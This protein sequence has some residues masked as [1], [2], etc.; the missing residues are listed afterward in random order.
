MGIFNKRPQD[1][2]KEDIFNL[3]GEVEGKQLDVKRH[4]F[5]VPLSAKD[6]ES[7]NPQS[8]DIERTKVELCT[9]VCAMANAHGGCIVLGAKDDKN[10]VTEIT[11]LSLNI[12]VEHAV[13][14]LQD[15]ALSGIEPALH[16]LHV[17][18]VVISEESRLFVI[19]ICVPRSLNA[20][21]WVKNGRR[22]VIRRSVN[23]ADMDI[24]EIRNAFVAGAT[25]VER[26][27]K[28]R[29]LR[30]ETINR[31]E[32]H[33]TSDLLAKDPKLVVHAIPLSFSDETNYDIGQLFAKRPANAALANRFLDILIRNGKFNIQG[34]TA[35]FRHETPNGE[36]AEYVHCWRNGAIEYVRNRVA[37]RH[38]FRVY[39]VQVES[40]EQY[41]ACAAFEALTIQEWLGVTPPILILVSFA[42]VKNFEFSYWLGAYEK[43]SDPVMV[44]SVSLPEVVIQSY[45]DDAQLVPELRPTFDAMAN[46]AGLDRSPRFSESGA[47]V[48]APQIAPRY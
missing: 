14:Q 20:P 32:A 9:D 30:L 34:H 27:R 17:Q 33:F 19:V 24:S 45:V 4:A 8:K 35:T 2:T 26:V 18:P 3:V 11:G 21:H 10:T 44:E 48:H 40:A 38:D 47:L 1:F 12:S 16:G 29:D 23:N 46:A 7:T 41:V 6:T 22:F 15:A 37:I 31:N 13:R 5:Q 39:G 42:G 36:L 25:Y 43:A 28:F